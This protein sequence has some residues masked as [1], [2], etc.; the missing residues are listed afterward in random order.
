M[1]PVVAGQGEVDE[2][3]HARHVPHPG[4]NALPQGAWRCRGR[5][6][7]FFLEFLEAD[8]PGVAVRPHWPSGSGPSGFFAAAGN[9][10]LGSRQSFLSFFGSGTLMMRRHDGQGTRLP[11]SAMAILTGSEQKSH[12]N[13]TYSGSAGLATGSSEKAAAASA[14][15]SAGGGACGGGGGVGGGFGAG[16]RPGI[17]DAGESLGR[18]R[19]GGRRFV[20]Y[21]FVVARGAIGM[22]RR[23]G[24]ARQR[25]RA[26]MVPWN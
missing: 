22:C 12:S 4:G 2:D 1:P 14:S 10:A 15:T 13:S 25:R 8:V 3:A 9:P 20:G 26:W 19:L 5:E 23:C 24:R 17:L 11:A 7:A 6:D 16:V 18:R 21:R